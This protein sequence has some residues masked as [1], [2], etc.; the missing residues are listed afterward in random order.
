MLMLMEPDME[1]DPDSSNDDDVAA[2]PSVVDAHNGP[3][4]VPVPP[5]DHLPLHATAVH[6]GIAANGVAARTQLAR[7]VPDADAPEPPRTFFNSK[8]NI[9]SSSR[10]VS[11]RSTRECCGPRVAIQSTRMHRPTCPT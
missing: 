4:I 2:G 3:P 8:E 9:S 6:L 5:G 7:S 1:V 10:M 11:R